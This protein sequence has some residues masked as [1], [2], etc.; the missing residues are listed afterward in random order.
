MEKAHLQ[1][2]LAEGMS[3]EQIG[4]RVGKHPSTVGYW[5]KRHGLTATGAARH[6]PRGGLRR[7]ELELLVEEGFSQPEMAARLDVSVTTVGYWLRRYGLQTLRTRVQELPL[8]Q[9]PRYVTRR[10]SRHGMSRFCRSSAGH[11]RCV[12]C[13]A[14]R[15]AQRRRKV[16]EILVEEA[17]GGCV[18]CGYQRYL[19]AL[20]F[21]HLDPM[22]KRFGIAYGGVARGI[23]HQRAEARKCILLCANCHAEVEAG[24]ASLP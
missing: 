18:I 1:G 14:D 21:H 15:V 17:G 22:S 8:E 9:R 5:I 4:R 10:C 16:K 20:Q 23:A 6:S 24:V 11:Y 13:R 3:L 2:F 19:G 12:Q 7:D